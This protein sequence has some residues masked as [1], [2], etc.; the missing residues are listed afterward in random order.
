MC[1]HYN[2]R[3]GAGGIRIWKMEEIGK[4]EG[5]GEILG[6]LAD[7]KI[8]CPACGKVFATK[9]GLLTHKR[10]VHDTVRHKCDLCDK[11]YARASHLRVHQLS[12]HQMVRFQC[13][14]CDFTFKTPQSL[15]NH[16]KIVHL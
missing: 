5:W 15:S 10:T 1:C 12:K 2:Q 9:Q 6:G 3:F 16:E 13:L 14:Q 4:V 11:S 8:E 7:D